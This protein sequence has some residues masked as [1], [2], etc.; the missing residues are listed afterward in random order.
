MEADWEYEIGG[1]APVIEADWPGLIDLRTH[2]ERM[3]EIGEARDFAPLATLLAAL[4][5]P[6]SPLWTSKCDLWEPAPGTLAGYIDILPRKETVFAERNDAETACRRY[7]GGLASAALPESGRDQGRE[8]SVALVIRQA[9]FGRLEGFGITAYLSAVR[10][11][12]TD[13]ASALGAAMAAFADALL[14]GASDA[15]AG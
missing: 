12:R 5:G 1:G 4:N 11:R 8:A 15:A 13:A 10:P 9:V 14:K 7:V 2:P 6:A 3:S